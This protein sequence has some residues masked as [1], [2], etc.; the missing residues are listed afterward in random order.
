MATLRRLRGIFFD[1]DDTLYSTQDFARLARQN[2]VRAMIRAGVRLPAD[3]LYDELLEVVREFSSNY[4]HH[5]DKL[6]LRLPA[7]AFAGTNPALIVA[8]AVA[9]YHDT[10]MES[11]RPFE[12]AA[13]FLGA[14][15]KTDLVRGVITDGWTVKQAEK[16][17]RIGVVPLLTSTA[18]FIS[19]QIGISK[20]NP[21]LYQRA[22]EATGLRPEQ[23]L[24][25]GDDPR[26]DIDPASAAGMIT[27]LFTRV[28]RDRRPGTAAPDYSAADYAALSDI[29]R[30][31]FEIAL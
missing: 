11:L 9:A 10:K 22:C 27:C 3:Q 20:P 1:I 15:A 21:K 25:V 14:L 30:K 16:L 13:A 12:D 31:E 6:L 8:S 17:V 2:A 18:I 24:Y 28:Q 7:A 23:T 5:F 26:N 29:L 19:D 4:D